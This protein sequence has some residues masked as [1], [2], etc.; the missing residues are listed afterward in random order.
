MEIYFRATEKVLFPAAKDFIPCRGE[1]CCSLRNL[2][3]GT[4]MGMFLQLLPTFSVF[5]FA[6]C[7][8]NRKFA[9]SLS[10]CKWAG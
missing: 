8:N 9:L 10:A 6:D 2:G 5:P 3:E 4:P 7:L 1:F